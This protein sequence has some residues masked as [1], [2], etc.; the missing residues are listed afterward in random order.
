MG[1]LYI[2]LLYL[3]QS[4]RKKR[5]T[6]INTTEEEKEKMREREGEREGDRKGGNLREG[7]K[8]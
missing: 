4:T 7:Q 5:K 3:S 1:G 6:Q 8:C 2:R